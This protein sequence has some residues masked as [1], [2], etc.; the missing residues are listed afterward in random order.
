MAVEVGK[1]PRRT[2]KSM[3]PAERLTALKASENVQSMTPEDF[4]A[5]TLAFGPA[6]QPVDNKKVNALTTHDLVTIES[7]FGDYRMEVIANFQGAAKIGLTIKGV[8]ADGSSCC[9]CC[10]PCCSC[11]AAVET[12]PFEA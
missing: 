6:H 4:E 9:C 11:T 1:G 8:T 12:D 5:M 3:F 7:L 2:V 10:T